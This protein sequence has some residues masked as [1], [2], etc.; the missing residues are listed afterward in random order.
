MHPPSVTQADPEKKAADDRARAEFVAATVENTER[1]VNFRYRDTT[2]GR[3]TN[4]TLLG[5]NVDAELVMCVFLDY[6]YKKGGPLMAAGSAL[7]ATLGRLLDDL[8]KKPTY[9]GSAAVTEAEK[10]M[11]MRTPE[12]QQEAC[13][14]FV[15]SVVCG[16]NANQVRRSR[17]SRSSS[18]LP[19][20]DGFRDL[21]QHQRLLQ[22]KVVPVLFLPV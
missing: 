20:A 16:K 4:P 7:F 11:H 2:G 15:V 19:L 5:V 21:P 6:M 12:A 13:A 17:R 1:F 14:N 8:K 3:I 22:R 9:N 10:G 18:Q